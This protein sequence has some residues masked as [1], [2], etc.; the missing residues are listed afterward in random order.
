MNANTDTQDVSLNVP[1]HVLSQLDEMVRSGC[2][3]DRQTAVATAVERLYAEEFPRL[4][5]RQL[6]F[7]RLNGTL[8]LG[9]TRESLQQAKLDRLEWEG[10]TK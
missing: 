2:F 10:K 4:T 8:H 6:A 9:T 7:A 3:K 5:A 1:P